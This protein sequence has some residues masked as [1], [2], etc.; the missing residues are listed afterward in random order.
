MEKFPNKPI[1]SGS[2]EPTAEIESD[3]EK[4]GTKFAVQ[5]LFYKLGMCG[6]D[7]RLF[8]PETSIDEI[9]KNLG[10]MEATDRGFTVR[11]SYKNALNLPR[12]FF[13]TPQECLDFIKKERNDYA[14]IIQEY[15]RLI[16][17]FELYDDG[18]VSYLQVLPGIWEVDATEAPD[19]VQEK[20]GELTIWRFR[21][22]R[23]A[24]LINDKNKFYKEKRDPFTFSQ[25]KE[26]YK[27]LESYKDRLEI[28]RKKFNP[29]FCH[30]YED[31]QGRFCFINLRNVGGVPINEG[32]PSA[33]HVVKGISDIETWD[34]N[35]PILFDVQTERDDDTPLIETIKALRNKE[36]KSVFVNYGILSHPAILL[37]EAGVQ[38]QQ[39][40][41]LYEKRVIS[42]KDEI[43]LEEK[44]VSTTDKI[45][46]IETYE[47]HQDVDPK[48]EKELRSPYIISLSQILEEDSN[49][50]G[51]KA[52][53]LGK[54][55]R[56]GFPI[57]RGFVI[58]TRVFR[59]WI[60][61]AEQLDANV[62]DQISNAFQLL[63][64]ENVAVRSSST[65]ED[66][67]QAS[68]AG[69]YKTSLNIKKEEVV[70]AVIEGFRSFYEPNA[71]AY[72]SEKAIKEGADMAIIVQEMIN[73]KVSGVLFTRNPLNRDANEDEFVINATFGLGEP[74]VSGRVPGDTFILDKTNNS[75]KESIITQKDTMLTKDGEIDVP[76]SIKSVSTLNNLQ[77]SQLIQIGKK[78][79]ELFGAPQDI[80]FAITHDKIWILQSRPI[81]KSGS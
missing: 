7:T 69:V 51:G 58:T 78:L 46:Q 57:P 11:F 2:V 63:K 10:E 45:E 40:Y 20:A 38:V 44:A 70:N 32:S 80:E 39:S 28:V 9:E 76:E 27:K 16:N 60:K 74:I 77:I 48:I 26:F 73:A 66:L 61:K 54:I 18:N 33:F 25:L 59:E 36:I 21:Q 13:K 53:N 15:T 62:S 65:V 24:K 43:I 8:E 37:R 4:F 68:S 47:I 56:A 23:E 31:D 3:V 29:L 50:V 34:G 75:I 12:G 42:G 71:Q 6:I 55:A 64:L 14:I 35:L 30:F 17:S 22:P 19:I 1:E 41:Q 49:F 5:K 67:S 72:R 52:Y 79:E 81:T